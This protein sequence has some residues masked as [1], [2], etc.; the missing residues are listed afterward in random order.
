MERNS[1]DEEE[2]VDRQTGEKIEKKSKYVDH[3]SADGRHW[4]ELSPEEKAKVK[5]KL[6]KKN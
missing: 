6:R 2:S 1:R 3:V 4:D 5:K